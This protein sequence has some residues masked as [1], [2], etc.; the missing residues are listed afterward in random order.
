MEKKNKSERRYELDWLRIITIIILFFY[1][2]AKPFDMFDFHINNY[3]RDLGMT[4]FVAYLSSWMMPIFFLL[5]GMSIFYSL[6]KREAG[7]FA[8]E[9]IKRIMIPFIFGILFLLSIH[10][11]FEGVHKGWVTST[12]FEFYAFRYFT[13][14]VFPF[15]GYYLW[16]L[17][18]L[19]IFS[20]LGLP[21][22]LYFRKEENHEKIEK[23]ANFIKKPG[24]I[25]LLGIPLVLTE[26]I[27]YALGLATF[28]FGGWQLPSYFIIVIYGFLF[29]SDEQFREIIEKNV[30]I[31]AITA[32]IFSGLSGMAY[33]FIESIILYHI[34]LAFAGITWLTLIVGLANKYLNKKHD[35]LNFLN[36]LVLPFYI[37]HQ[38]IIVVIAFYIVGMQAT[39]IAKYLFIVAIG[40][41]IT[42]G[43]VLL[44]RTN[45]V[46]R[47]LF[48]MRL[49]KKVE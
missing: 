44:V 28:G 2:S 35:K 47:F 1:H 12:Y 37:L 15:E 10:A 41:P 39:I 14:D 16:Y 9:R 42:V 30:V 27:T 25:L 4:I 46:T 36:E 8:K 45:N 43:L 7:V 23:L 49:K 29:A 17:W 22:F 20:I 32:P 18:A 21:I 26:L 38:T 5:S 34:C 11:Y 48:G 40:I 13:L 19:F 31:C 6:R 3:E 33:F 24:A